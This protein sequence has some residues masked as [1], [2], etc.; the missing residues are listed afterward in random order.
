MTGAKCSLFT[1]PCTPLRSPQKGSSADIDHITTHVLLCQGESHHW[2]MY[3][4]GRLYSTSYFTTP[5]SSDLDNNKWIFRYAKCLC[6][7][8]LKMI[9]ISVFCCLSQQRDPHKRSSEDS[10]VRFPACVW[11][12]SHLTMTK[13]LDIKSKQIAV[14]VLLPVVLSWLGHLLSRTS[15]LQHGHSQA[16]VLS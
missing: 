16:A 5:Y 2:K 9:N 11:S 13:N 1:L 6:I 7:N 3:G 15:A 14:H 10:K 12:L 8:K 4:L